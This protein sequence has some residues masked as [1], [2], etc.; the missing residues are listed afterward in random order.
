MVEAGVTYVRVVAAALPHL[1]EDAI[2]TTLEMEMIEGARVVDV[3]I[4]NV[5]AGPPIPAD[6]TGRSAVTGGQLVAL[7]T[8]AGPA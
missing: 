5:P 7:I 8:L 3:R 2:N 6:G 4:A 1:L